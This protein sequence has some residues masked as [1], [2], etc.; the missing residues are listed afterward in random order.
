[1]GRLKNANWDELTK[2]QARE[3]Y[4]NDEQITHLANFSKFH[5]NNCELYKLITSYALKQKQ[6]RKRYSIEIIL[7]V[8]RYH[9]DLTGKGD[10]FKVNNNYKPYYA[11]MFMQ[12]HRC[13]G[14]FEVRNSISEG[15]N[16]YHDIVFYKQWLTQ[17]ERIMNKECD[18][19]AE[20]AEDQDNKQ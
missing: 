4:S 14:F 2:M 11:R 15:H 5:R 12:E 8:V 9:T 17:M 13:E 3:K 1:M 16:F 7:N 19:D 18:E 6:M 10:P 20:R